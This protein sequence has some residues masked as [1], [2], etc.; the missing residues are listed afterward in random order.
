MRKHCK[1]KKRVSAAH[2]LVMTKILPEYATSHYMSL[3]SLIGGWCQPHQ[4]ET[5]LDAAK[6]LIFAGQDRGDQEAI[7]HGRAAMNALGNAV[8]RHKKHGKYG[9]SGD[10]LKTLREFVVFNDQWIPRCSGRVILEA[11]EAVTRLK[12]IVYEEARCQSL[13]SS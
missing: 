12:E 8:D 13:S 1:R 5:L 10:D 2:C 6:T 3:E 11:E 9:V 4:M 7:K